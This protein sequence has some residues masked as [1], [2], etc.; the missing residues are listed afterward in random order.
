ME[1][2]TDRGSL[3]SYN[4]STLGKWLSEGSIWGTCSS[5]SLV[6]LLLPSPSICT[7]QALPFLPSK[8]SLS[9]IPYL[10][11]TLFTF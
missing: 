7:S 1:T 8:T 2:R 3:T 6:V 9:C 11:G 5:L 10:Q 4:R